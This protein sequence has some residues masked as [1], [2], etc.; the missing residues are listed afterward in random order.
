M[1]VYS[2]FTFLLNSWSLFSI[3]VSVEGVNLAAEDLP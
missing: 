3:H 2:V 1:L